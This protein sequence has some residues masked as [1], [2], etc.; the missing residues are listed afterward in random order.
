MMTVC[1]FVPVAVDVVFAGAVEPDM[2]PVTVPAPAVV[3]VL[4]SPAGFAVRTVSAATEPDRVIVIAFTDPVAVRTTVEGILAMEEAPGGTM[5]VSTGPG[6]CCSV[7]VWLESEVGSGG[8]A[9]LE[10]GSGGGGAGSEE[11]SVHV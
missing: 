5:V 11:E 9:G 10:D 6:G 2:P 1:V 3:V 8:A 7:V 4:V